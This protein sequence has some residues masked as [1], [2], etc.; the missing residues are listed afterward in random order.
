MR[1]QQGTLFDAVEHKT[2]L[3]YQ[4]LVADLVLESEYLGT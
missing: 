4:S 2:H 1:D 3:E